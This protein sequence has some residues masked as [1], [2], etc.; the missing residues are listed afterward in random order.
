VVEVS[1]VD[2]ITTEQTWTSTILVTSERSE[3]GI[4]TSR[5]TTP[6]SLLSTLI[7]YVFFECEFGVWGFGMGILAEM[8]TMGDCDMMSELEAGNGDGIEI[9]AFARN[10]C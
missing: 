6:G 2:N 7:R 10:I 3:C 1:L 5:A 9:E 4:S 8:N